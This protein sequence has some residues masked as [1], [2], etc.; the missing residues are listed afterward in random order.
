MTAPEPVLFTQIPWLS[1]ETAAAAT[2]TPPPL[3][4]AARI[5]ACS[6]PEPLL[7]TMPLTVID[8]PPVPSAWAW[9]PESPPLTV[10]AS[11]ASIPAPMPCALMPSDPPVTS[12][13]A[14]IVRLLSPDVP[15]TL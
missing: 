5:P 13:P 12:A 7:V 8:A 10:P 2:K 14:E 15:P 9:M 4:L 3:P 1:P 11:M 6:V